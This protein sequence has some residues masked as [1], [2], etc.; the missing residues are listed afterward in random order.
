MDQ[1]VAQN[2]LLAYPD[3]NKKIEMNTNA[4]DLGLGAFTTQEVIPI[5]SI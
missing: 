2:D 4:N 1:I 3:F 5:S